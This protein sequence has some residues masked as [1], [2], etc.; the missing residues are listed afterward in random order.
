MKAS[1][2][3][4]KK[5]IEQKISGRCKLNFSNIHD[6]E[7]IYSILNRSMQPVKF[8][9][10]EALKTPYRDPGIKKKTTKFSVEKK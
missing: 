3:K 9:F 6:R 1:L 5:K 8:T 2:S 7:I 4:K 10:R